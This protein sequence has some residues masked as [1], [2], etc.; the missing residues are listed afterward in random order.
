MIEISKTVGR[1]AWPA[2]SGAY[3]LRSSCSQCFVRIAHSS[4]RRSCLIEFEFRTD[5]NTSF[6][7]VLILLTEVFGFPQETLE[8]RGSRHVTNAGLRKRLAPAFPIFDSLLSHTRSFEATSSVVM[9]AI[10]TLRSA[11]SCLTATG[12]T[13][14]FRAAVLRLARTWLACGWRSYV[15]AVMT[16]T[17]EGRNPSFWCP[18]A[19]VGM[20]DLSLESGSSPHGRGRFDCPRKNAHPRYL[21][22]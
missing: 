15:R 10:G 16:G 20:I 12:T 9:Q 8:R 1:F 6:D 5:L 13:N 21:A 11:T 2:A 3:V 18:S 14:R 4:F 17:L 7:H 22:A 19:L